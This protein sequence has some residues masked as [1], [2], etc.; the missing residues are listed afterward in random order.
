MSDADATPPG[1][2]RPVIV[3]TAGHI[4]HGKSSLVRA[5]TGIDPDRL[6]EEQARGMTIDL[7][8]ARYEHAGGGLVG[9][10][11][12]PGHERF[13]R[14]MVAGATSVDV[15]L[16]VV[17]ADDGVMPQTREHLAILEL[18]GARRGLVALTKIDLVEADLVQLAADDIEAFVAGT[19]LEGVPL[20]PVSSTSGQGLEALRAALDEQVAAVPPR[21]DGGPFRLP[22]QRVFSAKG[23]G[24]VVT[25]VP[26]SGRVGPGDVL[27][28][29][30]SGAPLRVRGVQAYGAARDEGHAGHSTALNISGASKDE[31][32]RGQVLASPGLFHARRRLLL[33]YRHVSDEEVLRNNHPVRLHV[34]TAE[35]MGRAVLLDAQN[36][37]PGQDA[38][39]Q[40]RLDT[41]VVAAAGDRYILRDAA[42]MEL[43]GG[44]AVL[45]S[46]TGRWKRFKP[47]VL[48]EAQRRRDAQHD[49]AA[50]LA[51]VVEL[52]GRRGL[53]L[54]ALAGE[55]A[56]THADTQALL[57]APLAAGTAVAADGGLFVDAGA[58]DEVGDEVVA[59]L[60][61]EHRRQPLLEWA[62]IGALRAA[63]AVDEP[64]LAAVLRRDSRLVT[65]AGGR[66]RLARHRVRLDDDQ[67]V[68]REQVLARLEAAGLQP[69]A[70]DAGELGLSAAKG[71]ELLAML[72]A[73]GEVVS[74]AGHLYH[75]DA[76]AELRRRV[77]AHGQA[78]GG[79]IEIP[80]LRDELGTT[81]KF[82]IPLLEHFD[83]AGVTRRQGDRR[84]L[85]A[86]ASEA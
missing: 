39:L 55:L 76:L 3:G 46:G 59:A 33:S 69:V 79:A 83:T 58:L 53:T 41:P 25:G 32:H 68:A 44:G 10:I 38:W 23:H 17:A 60:E 56:L 20:L 62:D 48:D 29:V 8:F 72:T 70:V 51:V 74:V 57:A 52:S 21:D 22:V 64:V 45:A 75:A 2:I 27:E 65:E 35:I 67:R 82:L 13:I 78:R 28:L 81:R 6:A 12:V 34:G 84:V 14:N 86:G 30:D 49:P 18:L 16:L 4:D 42:S 40:L 31:V 7:G 15:V 1:A 19:F 11:D 80:E 24:T 26:V 66:V 43:L 85:R 54:G 5:L 9:I 37:L 50:L 73:G 61:A 63:V 47:R 77:I 71:R 36:A